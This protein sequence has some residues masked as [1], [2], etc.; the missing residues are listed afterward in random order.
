[1]SFADR[2]RAGAAE[3]VKRQAEARRATSKARALPMNALPGSSPKSVEPFNDVLD[4]MRVA[5]AACCDASGLARFSAR[6]ATGLTN[7]GLPGLNAAS[8]EP[9]GSRRRTA[10][11]GDRRGPRPVGA[12]LQPADPTTPGY[13]PPTRARELQP[14]LNR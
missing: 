9:T 8:G 6:G 14:P 10:D 3:K 13:M 7:R 5:G 2:V 12:D 4:S 1:M 11:Q